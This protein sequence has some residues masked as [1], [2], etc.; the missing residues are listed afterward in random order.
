MSSSPHHHFVLCLFLVSFLCVNSQLPHDVFTV[1]IKNETPSVVTRYCT[2]H[3]EYLNEDQGIE[4]KPGE[5]NNITG[6]IVPGR[7][8]FV[9]LL[10]LE[11]NARYS[12]CLIRM[13]QVFVTFLIKYVYGKYKK[14]DYAC[15]LKS[16]VSLFLCTHLQARKDKQID[17]RTPSL[18]HILLLVLSN[19]LGSVCPKILLHD[20]ILYVLN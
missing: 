4:L 1:I 16:G 2:V 19:M 8:T 15:C 6:S 7:N 5:V 12:I 9:C 14:M 11:E 18:C 13:T 17:P 20:V 10:E 3:G